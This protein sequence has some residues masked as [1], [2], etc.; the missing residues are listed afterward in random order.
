MSTKP[1]RI[2]RV[3]QALYERSA[4]LSGHCMMLDRYPENRPQQ[5]LVRGLLEELSALLADLE[6]LTAPARP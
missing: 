1:T 5:E 4:P 6:R 2:E 3:A